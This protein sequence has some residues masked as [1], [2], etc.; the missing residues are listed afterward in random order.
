MAKT[1]DASQVAFFERD[2]SE[3]MGGV[4]YI[5]GFIAPKEA[6]ELLA[7]YLRLDWRQHIYR[8]NGKAP[9]LYVWMG[10]PYISPNLVSKTVTTEWTAEAKRIKDRVEQVTGCTFDSLNMNRYRHN[11]DSIGWHSD[12]EAEGRWDFPIA[13][14]SL[15]AVRRFQW[16]RKSDDA[17]DSQAVEHGSLFIMPAGFQRDYQHRL[18]KQEKSCG[19]RINLTFRRMLV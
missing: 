15:G 6:D 12:S 14:V 7:A 1:H 19:E 8:V 2:A 18:P 13:S 3:L 16:K 10:V 9:R 11:R 4:T 5:P 17:T